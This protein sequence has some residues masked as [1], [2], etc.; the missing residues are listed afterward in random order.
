MDKRGV[1]TVE[2]YRPPDSRVADADAQISLSNEPPR[3]VT[4]SLIVIST[5][6]AFMMFNDAVRTV[7]LLTIPGGGVAVAYYA[8]WNAAN[9]VVLVFAFRGHNWA[10]LGTVGLLIWHALSLALIYYG[11]VSTALSRSFSLLNLWPFYAAT[12]GPF[13]VRV[14]ATAMLFRPR[15]AAW[16]RRRPVGLAQPDPA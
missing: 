12:L 6:A 9:A 2:R 11:V 14:V 3:V 4:V 8:V 10:R 1:M 15:A 13:V 5:I 16:F 7:R